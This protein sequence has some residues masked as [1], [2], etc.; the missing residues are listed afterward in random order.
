M[1]RAPGPQDAEDIAALEA[2][3]RRKKA[4]PMTEHRDDIGSWAEDREHTYVVGMTVSVDERRAWL[5]EM[6]ALALASGALPK[7]LVGPRP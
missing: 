1:K 4:T 7:A 6:L 5:E 3:A 2:I